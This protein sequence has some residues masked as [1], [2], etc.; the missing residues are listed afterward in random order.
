MNNDVHYC[1][2]IT[3]LHLNN[4]G[5]HELSKIIEER[6]INYLIN[7]EASKTI[8]YKSSHEYNQAEKNSKS[9]KTG[10]YQY[11]T[12][13]E[14]LSTQQSYDKHH[15]GSRIIASTEKKKTPP[16]SMVKRSPSSPVP[17]WSLSY[18]T[19]TALEDKENS[20]LIVNDNRFNNFL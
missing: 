17:R 10:V 11:K 8:P 6:L 5:N 18:P 15:K 13:S 12:Y 19:N 9:I 14:V 1:K 16:G 7:N 4:D 2:Y 20:K 3:G